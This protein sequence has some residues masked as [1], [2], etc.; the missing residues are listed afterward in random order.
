MTTTVEGRSAATGSVTIAALVVCLAA[1]L[2]YVPTLNNYFVRDDFGVVE[3]LASKPAWY[4]PRWFYT[5]WTDRIWGDIADEVRPFMAVSYQLTALGGAASPFLH[6]VMNVALHAATG[7]L[8]LVM[9]RW[10]AGL[11]LTAS[12][13]A[14]TVFVLLPV[15]AE[16]VAWITGRVDSMPALFYIAAFIAYARWRQKGATDSRWYVGSLVLFFAALFTKQTTI[17]MVATLAAWDV[18]ADGKWQR[19]NGKWLRPYVPYVLMTVGYMW[20]RYVLFGQVAREGQLNAEGLRYFFV[21]L[22]R[23]LS[24]VITGDADANALVAWGVLVAALGAVWWLA[25]DRSARELQ[26]L[27]RLLLFFGPVWWIIGIIP[28]VVAGYESPRHVYLASAGWAVV[29]GILFDLAWT[30]TVSVTRRRVVLAAAVA[31]AAFY[32]VGLYKEV[33]YWR[34]LAHVSRKVMLDTRAE[35]MAAAPGSLIVIGAP[36]LSW[37]WA[38]PFPVKPPY[39]RVDLTTRVFM[40]SPWLLHCCRNQWVDDTRRTLQTWQSRHADA[41]VIVLRWDETSGALS[42]ITDREYPAL[43]SLVPV[44]LEVRTRDALSAAVL[45]IVDDL[46][47]PTG[48]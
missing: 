2:P 20:L 34:T 9:A 19:V 24:R 27:G 18:L 14:A 4:F 13:F 21:L 48:R 5:P 36:K 29:L 1:V 30:S 45:K 22:Q 7:L 3:L 40:I 43:R 23:H 25:R 35:A 10:L 38:M 44:L 33:G 47:V 12:A 16:T 39:T 6:H 41:P 37:E 17:T 46:P 11:S 31:I 28:T 42:R 26:H 32:A 8:V 15:Q